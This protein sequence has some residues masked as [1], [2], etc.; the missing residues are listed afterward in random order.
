M[1]S[2]TTRSEFKAYC[3]RKLGAPVIEINVE[4][5]IVEGKGCFRE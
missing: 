2:P 5:N 3:L 1:A 4:S